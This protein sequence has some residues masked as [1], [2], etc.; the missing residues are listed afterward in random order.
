MGKIAFR[1]FDREQ[2]EYILPQ[3]F[4]ILATNMNRIAPTGNSYEDDKQ[5]WMSHM[6]TL[7]KNQILL[8]YVDEKL[9][10]YFQYCIEQDVMLIEEI[11]IVP[12]YQRTVLFYR[13]FRFAASMIPTD[14][15]YVEAY[16]NKRNWNSQQIA[17]KL[18]MKI[19]GENKNGHSWHY[20]GELASFKKYLR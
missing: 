10:G 19:V 18:G 7:Q 4:D 15:V 9:S 20:Q 1:F 12:N 5:M 6:T 11:Q 13:F 14:V 16:V 17:K 2:S 3:I 8:M